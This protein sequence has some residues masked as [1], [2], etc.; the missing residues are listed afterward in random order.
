VIFDVRLALLLCL[1]D[2]SACFPTDR[3]AG[4]PPV[5][6]QT[7]ISLC[8]QFFDNLNQARADFEI[9]GFLI[10]LL[11][12]ATFFLPDG[13]SAFVWAGTAGEG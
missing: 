3:S 10:S 1:S 13:T 11:A 8:S 12:F 5:L 2:P 9:R 7:K 6:I 4:R